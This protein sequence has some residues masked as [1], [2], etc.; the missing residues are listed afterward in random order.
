MV[1][2]GDTCA[3]TYEH[4][5]LSQSYKLAMF[6]LSVCHV[7]LVVFNDPVAAPDRHLSFFFFG[8]HRTRS[9]FLFC[10]HRPRRCFCFLYSTT[11]SLL[12]TGICKLSCALHSGCMSSPRCTV[13]ACVWR[14]SQFLF[15]F[16]QASACPSPLC[17]VDAPLWSCS[18][19]QKWCPRGRR[20]WGDPF[21]GWRGGDGRGG[22][23]QE[24]R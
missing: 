21:G 7:V 24:R 10:I 13:D 5:M 11:P 15:I 12:P 9:C 14:C 3:T 2:E 19:F 6:I 23:G 17:S 1:L 18:Q 16:F 22:G 8:V 4:A 20:G